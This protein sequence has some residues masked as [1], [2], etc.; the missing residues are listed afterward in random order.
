[1]SELKQT[2]INMLEQKSNKI[3]PENLKAGIEIFE[4]EGIFTA[5]GD[6]TSEDIAKDKIAYVNGEKIVG[7]MEQSTS[8]NNAMVGTIIDYGSS[9]TSGVNVII[10]SIND[11]LTLKGDNASY[12]FY[13]CTNLERVKE[14]DISKAT[15]T[16]YMFG[17]CEKL[18]TIPQ[19]DTS[20]VNQTNSMFCGCKSL[21]EVPLL[22]TTNVT[23]M[24]LMFDSCSLLETIPV[25]NTSKV[26][27]M[28]TM[29]RYCSKLS[30]ES[31]NNILLMCSNATGVSSSNKTLKTVGLTAEQATT[32]TTL[33]NYQAFLNAGWQTGY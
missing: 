26:T 3:T 12:L 11:K 20:K 31:L 15:N 25:F 24:N 33:S 10:K 9:S 23:N 1:M 29:F 27:K 18:A 22:D 30:N 17:Y 14:I 7:T 21:K 32:C 16:T 6:A 5:D 8:E 19:I 13:M 2:L 28:S 4:V